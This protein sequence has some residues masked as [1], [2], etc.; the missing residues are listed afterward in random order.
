MECSSAG[1]GEMGGWAPQD[2]IV[3]RDLSHR[4]CFLKVVSQKSI[5]IQSVNL[6]SILSQ[7]HQSAMGVLGILLNLPS[8]FG[9]FI[10]LKARILDI[11][12]SAQ[13]SADFYYI[14]FEITSLQ[15]KSGI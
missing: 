4:Q 12:T 10:T 7:A 8:N 11:R 13:E 9:L 14:I 2:W 5:S 1:H 15:S 6:F 3:I